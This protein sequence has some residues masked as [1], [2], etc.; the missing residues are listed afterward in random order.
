MSANISQAELTLL[1]YLH[2]HSGGSGERIGLAPKPITREL[3]ISMKQ[4]AEESAALAA[5]GLAGVRNFRPD[6][7]DVPSLKCSSIWLT[8]KGA[9]Y[10]KGRE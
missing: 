1:E 5:Q 9:D 3:R 2:K 4:F 6:A 10:L 7:N 8:R